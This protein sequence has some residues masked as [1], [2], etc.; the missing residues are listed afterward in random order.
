MMAAP[1]L[2][3]QASGRRDTHCRDRETRPLV[4]AGAKWTCGAGGVLIQLSGG[5]AY[6]GIGRH[7]T[8]RW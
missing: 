4:D 8:L 5:C 3:G 6:G 7:A 2:F 1:D